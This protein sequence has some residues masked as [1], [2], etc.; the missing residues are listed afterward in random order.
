MRT[1]TLML[2][3]LLLAGCTPDPAENFCQE[4]DWTSQRDGQPTVCKVLWCKKSS[5]GAGLTTLWCQPAPTPTPER[6]PTR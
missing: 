6:G 2:A 5:Y 3:T 1:L 4:Y